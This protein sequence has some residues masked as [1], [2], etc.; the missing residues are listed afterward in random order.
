MACASAEEVARHKAGEP[1]EISA[2]QAEVE[3]NL[4]LQG[5]T[6]IEDKLQE[7]APVIPCTL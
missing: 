6:G 2:L 5:A 4:T 3:A 7:G 1:S